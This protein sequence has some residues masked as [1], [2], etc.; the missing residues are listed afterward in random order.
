MRQLTARDI[1]IATVIGVLAADVHLVK[2]GRD[3]VSSFIGG[4]LNGPH[5]WEYRGAGLYLICHFL[6]KP[7]KLGCVDPLHRAACLIRR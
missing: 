1:T 5:K 3:S 2:N 6:G 7:K 4:L